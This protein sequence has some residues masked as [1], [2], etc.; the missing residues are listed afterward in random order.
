VGL[1]CANPPCALWAGKF[2]VSDQS[3]GR[4]GFA[5][6]DRTFALFSGL[7]YMKERKTEDVVAMAAEFNIHFPPPP[8]GV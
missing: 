5:A 3:G 7:H 1:R 2:S 8:P 4:S 6:F